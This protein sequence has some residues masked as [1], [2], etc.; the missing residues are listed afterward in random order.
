MDAGPQNKP[1]IQLSRIS[2]EALGERRSFLDPHSGQ[3]AGTAVVKSGLA[4]AAI[5]DLARDQFNRIWVLDAWAGRVGTEQLV[6]QLVAHYMKW[7][8]AQFGIE[9]AGQQKLFVDTTRMILRMRGLRIPVLGCEPSTREKKVFRIRRVVQPVVAEQRL[10]IN[11]SLVELRT[12][13]A[14]FP[15]GKTM[16]IVDALAGAIDMLPLMPTGEEET[17][18]GDNIYREFLVEQGL[19]SAQIERRIMEEPTENE[20]PLEPTISQ[21]EV[22]PYFRWA[23]K[24]RES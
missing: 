12:E 21:P 20:S 9:A 14:Q 18:H 16:D 3:E 6:D 17:E 7:H 11:A 22:S 1:E 8:P 10:L 2:L 19:T 13:M 4:R 5:V 15:T 23:R 24:M